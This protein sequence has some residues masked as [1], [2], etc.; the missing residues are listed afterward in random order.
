MFLSLLLLIMQHGSLGDWNPWADLGK[1]IKAIKK[2]K[3][4]KV[5]EKLELLQNK[6][7]LFYKYLYFSIDMDSKLI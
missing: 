3:Y 7:N 1:L 5:K 2:L 4:F 6:L